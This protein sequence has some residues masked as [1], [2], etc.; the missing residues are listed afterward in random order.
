MNAAGTLKLS[1]KLSLEV[2]HSRRS[3]RQIR[4]AIFWWKVRNF[5]LYRWR[6]WPLFLI[7]AI[8]RMTPVPCLV[9]HTKLFLVLRKKNGEVWDYGCV[10]RML[11]TTAGK[12]FVTDNWQGTTDL[13]TM[14]YHGLG[15][16]TT[17]AAVGDTAL[18]SELSTDYATNSTRPTGTVTEASSVIMQSVGVNTLDGSA[19]VTEWGLLS[20]AATGGGVLFDRQVFAA[21]NMVAGDSLTSTYQLTHA[22]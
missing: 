19:T 6:E 4:R 16:G 21:V 22:E 2:S 7:L 13:D 3:P 5:F 20:Q 1:G 8:C 9:A 17:A 15:E 14:K 10:G 11:I 18:E 12:A